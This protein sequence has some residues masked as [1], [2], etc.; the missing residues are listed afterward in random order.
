VKDEHLLW[1]GCEPSPPSEALRS[2]P[3]TVSLLERQS[4]LVSFKADLECCG[5]VID[6]HNFLGWV[7]T[8][9]GQHAAVYEA[10]GFLRGASKC[11]IGR[12]RFTVARRL[13]VLGLIGASLLAAVR[14]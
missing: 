6:A 8:V 12:N 1:N 4:G 7:A 13:T 11:D 10:Y 9:D 3:E 14:W 5:M 2:E